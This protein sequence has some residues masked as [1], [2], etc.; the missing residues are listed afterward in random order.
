MKGLNSSFISL[1]PKR[2]NP[3][4]IENYR[5]ISLIGSIYKVLAKVLSKRLARVLDAIISHKQSAFIGE[6]NIL[7]GV[8]IFNH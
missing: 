1:I 4:M 6:R 3:V 8:L 2:L 7:D 5:P